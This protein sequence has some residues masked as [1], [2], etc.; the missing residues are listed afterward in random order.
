MFLTKYV[1]YKNIIR[2]NIQIKT[3]KT[4]LKQKK[5]VLKVWIHAEVFRYTEL[6]NTCRPM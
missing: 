6:K 1:H 2:L 5:I 4:A 3:W